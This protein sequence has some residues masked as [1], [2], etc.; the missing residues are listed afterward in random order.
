MQASLPRPLG[1]ILVT[2]RQ[3]IAYLEDILVLGISRNY[4]APQYS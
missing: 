1:G 3:H 2:V 4:R